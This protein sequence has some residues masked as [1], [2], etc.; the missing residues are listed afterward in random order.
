MLIYVDFETIWELIWVTFGLQNTARAEKRDSTIYIG[1]P[2]ATKT[3][4]GGHLFRD[5]FGDRFWEAFY[6]DLC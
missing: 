6:V 5:R 3:E 4:P 1:C 2:R